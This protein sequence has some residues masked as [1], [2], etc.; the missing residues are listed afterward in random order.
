MKSQGFDEETDTGSAAVA[1]SPQMDTRRSHLQR[2]ARTQR[3]AGED[4]FLLDRGVSRMAVMTGLSL[5]GKTEIIQCVVQL[6]WINTRTSP[7]QIRYEN[8]YEKFFLLS[9]TMNT[10]TLKINTKWTHV[11]RLTG[12]MS[13]T[14]QFSDYTNGSCTH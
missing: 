10:L 1:V 11:L 5:L 9:E 12:H 7:T 13:S 6:F 14:V 8:A 2:T 4:V 3:E